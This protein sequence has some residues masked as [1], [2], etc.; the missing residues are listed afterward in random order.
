M[1]QSKHPATQMI[2]AGDNPDAST[3]AVAPLYDSTTFSFDN[4]AELL[5]V[6]EGRTRAAFYTRYGMNPSITSLEQRLAVLDKAERSLAYA[7]GMAA[8]SSV[9]LAYGRGGIVCTGEIYG[10]TTGFLNQATQLGIETRFVA[11]Q[12]YAAL[13]RAL[14]AG[15]SLLVFETPA[16]PTLS[17]TDIS[18]VA[19]L[20]HQFDARVA[21]DNTFATSINQSPLHLGA[22]FAIQSATK[23]LGG[24]SD[25]TAGVVSGSEQLLHSLNEWRSSLGQTIA[26]EVAHKLKRSLITLPLRV[27]RHNQNAMVVAEFLQQHAMIDRVYYPGLEADPGH[28]IAGK[29]MSGFGGML[30]FTVNGGG[31]KARQ[32]VDRL[33]LI[34]LAPSLG[35]AESLATQPV[36]TSH[37]GLAE[38]MLREAGISAAM[39]RLSVGLE[40]A[41]D[42]IDDLEQALS[43][44]S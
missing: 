32:L 10:G 28:Q 19:A 40:H 1:S 23:Y 8:I 38:T 17:V 9:C 3:A 14:S 27:E 36:F 22:D 25:L 5:D 30:S 42:L 2:H 43:A 13:A 15:A 31:E 12:D 20:A 37:H 7:S 26:A 33:A 24:H 18:E 11:A 16:N 4:T 29:Q 41:D 34:K 6:V 21:V 39:I 44:I 35:G